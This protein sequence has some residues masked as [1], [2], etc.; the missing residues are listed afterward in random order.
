MKSKFT[1]NPIGIFILMLQGKVS[2]I[3]RV[4]LGAIKVKRNHFPNVVPGLSN[5]QFGYVVHG[6]LTIIKNNTPYDL[7]TRSTDG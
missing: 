3:A 5:H 2:Y 4:Q 1:L 6:D 7:C